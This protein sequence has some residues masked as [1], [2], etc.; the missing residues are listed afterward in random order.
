MVNSHLTNIHTRKT[1]TDNV[2]FHNFYLTENNKCCKYICIFIYLYINVC[3][4]TVSPRRYVHQCKITV[5]EYIKHSVVKKWRDWWHL[6][7]KA[8]KYFSSLPHQVNKCSKLAYNKPFKGKP[9]E[10]SNSCNFLWSD[11]F[12]F[13]WNYQGKYN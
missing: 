6:R 10:K 11:M 3:V 7:K 5:K 12:L 2:I 8:E 4:N 13:M 1:I 9:L